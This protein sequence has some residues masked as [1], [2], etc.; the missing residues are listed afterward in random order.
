[1]E[2]ELDPLAEQ[3][4]TQ[5]Q[6]GELN[7]IQAAVMEE[8]LTLYRMLPKQPQVEVV[9]EALVVAVEEVLKMEIKTVQELEP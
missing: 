7:L 2:V 9:A 8:Q 1:M 3:E 5:N 4:T 6:A